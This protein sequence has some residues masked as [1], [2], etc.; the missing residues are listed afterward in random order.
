MH[1]RG[2]KRVTV[3]LL[4][5]PHTAAEHWTQPHHSCRTWIWAWCCASIQASV[6]NFKQYWVVYQVCP[7]DWLTD[8]IAGVPHCRLGMLGSIDANTGS[9][10]LGWDTDQ[11]PMDIKNATLVMKVCAGYTYCVQS[12]YMYYIISCPRLYW[13]QVGWH[14]GDS[15]LTAKCVVNPLHWK[16]CSL[17]TLVRS[18]ST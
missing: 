16:T 5:Y 14:P 8:S 6:Y 2:W 12:P 4:T 9:P 17:P 7:S 15:T 11:F 13:R 1:F 10:D 18:A 3:Y